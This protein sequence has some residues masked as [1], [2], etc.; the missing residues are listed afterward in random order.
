MTGFGCAITIPDNYTATIVAVY[1][2]QVLGA[3]CSTL[4]GIAVANHHV[5]KKAFRLSGNGAG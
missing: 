1:P 2:E 4:F 5:P 3:V